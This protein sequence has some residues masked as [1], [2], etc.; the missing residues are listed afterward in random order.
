MKQ[1]GKAIDEGFLTNL[2]YKRTQM[3]DC[4]QN[5]WILEDYP[6]TREQAIYMAKADLQP[7]NVFFVR[8]P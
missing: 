5:G 3:K 2:I 6:Q 8:I 1:D 7:S 4:L